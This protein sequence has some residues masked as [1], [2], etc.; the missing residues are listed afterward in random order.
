MMIYR[1]WN[2][3]TRQEGNYIVV[4]FTDPDGKLYSEPFCFYTLDE[5]LYYGKLCIDRFIRAKMLQPKET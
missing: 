2:L 4:D 1:Q 3:F 5:A